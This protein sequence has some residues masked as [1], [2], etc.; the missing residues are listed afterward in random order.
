MAL[1]DFLHDLKLIMRHKSKKKK[2]KDQMGSRSNSVGSFSTVPEED[3]EVGSLLDNVEDLLL[4]ES[5]SPSP[6]KES[7]GLPI[8]QESNY[9]DSSSNRG[10]NVNALKTK[11]PGKEVHEE[12]SGDDLPYELRQARALLLESCL[13]DE[14]TAS[15]LT[16]DMLHHL[17]NERQTNDDDDAD[18]GLNDSIAEEDQVE[19]DDEAPAHVATESSLLFPTN[20]NDQVLQPSIFTMHSTSLE[21]E[22][23]EHLG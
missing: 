22:I 11:S 14:T 20:P 3:E 1:G 7:K 18:Q 23:E 19:I 6:R 17:S 12:S 10:R 9:D 15:L 2:S 13:L 21:E 16:S 5:S 8:M 4:D